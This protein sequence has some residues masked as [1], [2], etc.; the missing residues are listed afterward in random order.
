MTILDQFLKL[1][2][3]LEA[4]QDVF[5]FLT[6]PMG[7]S[8]VLAVCL[9]FPIQILGCDAPSAAALSCTVALTLF[10]LLERP[11]F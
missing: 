1:L 5:E 4:G 3:F 11:D 6:H 2:K 9:Y 7:L 8:A 10:C